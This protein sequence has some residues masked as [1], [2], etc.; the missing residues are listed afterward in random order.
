MS[1]CCCKSFQI[2]RLLS[3][4]LGI[5]E[6]VGIRSVVV[7]KIRTANS[8]MAFRPF[9]LANIQ[10]KLASYSLCMCLNPLVIS[11]YSLIAVFGP[12]FVVDTMA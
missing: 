7:L 10:C 9:G 11:L 1:C 2:S 12:F 4:V 6:R 8:L 5:L 3:L